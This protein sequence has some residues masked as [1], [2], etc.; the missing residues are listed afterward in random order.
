LVAMDLPEKVIGPAAG[1]Q[2]RDGKVKVIQD[3]LPLD[4]K[5][6]ILGQYVG[7]G[8]K[9][10]Y[11]EDD[12]IKPEQQAKAK[13]TCTFAQL[14]VRFNSERWKGVPFIIKGGKALH[15]HKC[16]IR[17]QFKLPER[18]ARQECEVPVNE[19]VLHVYP[20]EAIWYKLNMKTP[21]LAQKPMQS[22]LDLTYKE[23]YEGV[24]LPEAYTRLLLDGLRGKSE[25]FVR[26]DELLGSWKLF[27]PLLEA[28][29]GSGKE[30]LKYAYG[31]RGPEEA[32]KMCEKLGVIHNEGYQYPEKKEG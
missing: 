19:L 31:S 23:R 30:P 16:E 11:L 29:E 27:S 13:K 5:E 26:S 32:D 8:G 7:A 6:V 18:A 15:E 22:E 21:G 20:N 9:P 14:V 12:S 17:V 24:Y 28:L 10:G 4:P 1:K 2:I 3:M 25:N